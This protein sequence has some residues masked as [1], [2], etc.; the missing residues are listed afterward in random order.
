MHR[1]AFVLA[2]AG[3]FAFA[4]CSAAPPIATPT[5]TPTP[6]LERP[7]LH[8]WSGSTIAEKT[9]RAVIAQTTQR[10]GY[11]PELKNVNPSD[12][13]GLLYDLADSPNAVAIGFAVTML[14]DL[15]GGLEPP[16]P[17]D[18]LSLLASEIQDSAQLLATTPLDGRIVWAVAADSPLTSLADL[19]AWSA[20][21]PKPI[22]IPT[23]VGSRSDGIPSLEVVYEANVE[24]KYQDD[25]LKRSEALLSGAVEVAAFRACDFTELAGFK[26]LEDPAG[27]TVSDP[28]VVLLSPGLADAHPEAVLAFSDVLKKINEA[29]FTD[30][31]SK[32]A[33]GVDT[34]S[35]VNSWLI[36]YG[37]VP[38]E[39]LG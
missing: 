1:R 3:L 11:A 10:V 18:V 4:A 35:W 37:N 9:V 31:Q 16:A 12:V 2:V 24:I 38:E 6:T 7:A 17:D 22:A 26:L 19:K 25:A 15:G 13:N 8:F 28:M 34:E 36:E 20:A 33:S 27:I 5:P 30:L 39:P 32:V 21:A 14:R 29:N 23:F